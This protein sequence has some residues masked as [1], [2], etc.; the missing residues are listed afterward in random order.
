MVA[1]GLPHRLITLDGLS[2]WCALNAFT[3]EEIGADEVFLTDQTTGSAWS[4]FRVEDWLQLKGLVLE[5]VEPELPMCLTLARLHDRLLGC[6]FSIDQQHGVV[7][8]ADFA[9]AAQS[10]EAIG[11]TLLQM[12]SIIDQTVGLLEDVVESDVAADEFAID[13]AFG[14]TGSLRV[15]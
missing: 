5:D 10:M 6:R 1:D 15:H 8:V 3:V 14:V 9:R 13:R 4:L 11:E 7:I 2:Q 12:Q